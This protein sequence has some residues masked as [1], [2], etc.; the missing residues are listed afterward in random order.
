MTAPICYRKLNRQDQRTGGCA[1]RRVDGPPRVIVTSSSMF[2]LF[3]SKLHEVIKAAAPLVAV[4]IVVQ[5]GF[6]HAPWAEFL[7]FLAGTF[8]VVIGMVLLFAGVEFGILPMGQ[9]IGGELPKKGSLLLIV[10]VAFALGF[11]TTVAEPDVLILAAQA[12]TVSGG[13]ISRREVLY[14][15]AIGVALFTGLA[16]L[17]IIFAWS[18]PRLLA[19]AYGLMLLLSL[20]TP[21]RYVPLA[22]DAGSVTTGVLTAPVLISMAFGVSAVLARRSPVADGLGLLGFASI[23]PVLAIM[24]L[25][26]FK[27]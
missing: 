1:G 22:Y 25:A 24:L 4:V 27:S 2:G 14:V 15:T 26:L 12:G 20:V 19:A 13:E 6:V 3:R 5:I 17:R 7:Q 23:G 16:M 8:L 9:F 18:M 11:A 10:G 21:D